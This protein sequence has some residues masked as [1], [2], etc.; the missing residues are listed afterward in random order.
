MKTYLIKVT[1]EIPYPREFE[2]RVQASNPWTAVRTALKGVRKEL[3]KRRLAH[4][5]III[6]TL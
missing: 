5:K 2:Y 1:V 4:Y 6:D 3:P